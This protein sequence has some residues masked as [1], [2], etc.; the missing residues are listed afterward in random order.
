MEKHKFSPSAPL[1]P[2]TQ[3]NPMNTIQQ[4][5]N[6]G[7]LTVTCPSCKTESPFTVGQLKCPLCNTMIADET[8]RCRNCG[9]DF[10]ALDS[11]LCPS[12]G[13]HMQDVFC[14]NCGIDYRFPL[15][16]S[17][18][19]CPDC[20]QSNEKYDFLLPEIPTIFLETEYA[21]PDP[22]T[23]FPFD[24]HTSPVLL[25]LLPTTNLPMRRSMPFSRRENIVNLEPVFGDTENSYN[26]F[27]YKYKI[28]TVG[29]ICDTETLPEGAGIRL[30]I[31]DKRSYLEIEK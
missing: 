28:D 22:P 17:P 19:P 30:K 26:Y 5:N 31:K 10:S 15:N 14:K 20:G 6:A 13:L 27:F 4:T 25:N 24:E 11:P 23:H 1:L 7:T 9:E 2:L 18:Y 12:C 8:I 16:D 21:T 3:V 29:L